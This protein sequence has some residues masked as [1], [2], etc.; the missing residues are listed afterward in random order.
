MLLSILNVAIGKV[1]SS[2]APL[3]VV[4]SNPGDPATLL[5]AKVAGV[6][7]IIAAFASIVGLALNAWQILLERTELRLTELTLKETQTQSALATENMSLFKAQAARK[8]SL[9]VV[10]GGV[11]FI[12][13]N[14][15]GSSEYAV[16]WNV[17]NSGD[18]G[19]EGFRATLYFSPSLGISTFSDFPM[20]LGGPHEVEKGAK[21]TAA[22]I[23]AGRIYADDT[24]FLGNISVTADPGAHFVRWVLKSEDERVP[25]SG[26]SD[27][28]LLVLAPPDVSITAL[29]KA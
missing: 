22:E 4:V 11:Q 24:L 21:W 23:K 10:L 5:W 18:R 27:P 3:R 17:T 9:R 29:K 25:S 1:T 20:L 19:V 8:S 14:S 12:Q 6:A 26:Y 16:G 7:A 2:P 13:F 15:D 28:I